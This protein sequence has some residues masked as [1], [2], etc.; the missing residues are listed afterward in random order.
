MNV[1]KKTSFEETKWR[2]KMEREDVQRAADKLDERKFK[3]NDAAIQSGQVA[4]RTAALVNGGAVLAVLA[5][6]GGLIGQ[7]KIELNQINSVAESLMWFAYGV[8]AAVCSLGTAY[9]VN[10]C[11]RWELDSIYQTTSSP[12]TRESAMSRWWRCATQLF[13]FVALIAGILSLVLFVWGMHDLKASIGSLKAV[14][15]S[16]STRAL[17]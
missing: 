4:I 17:R 1:S 7:G 11:R 9:I 14:T 13:Q 10:Y 12:F 8:A 6:L 16:P 15:S 5:F 2:Q 3:V